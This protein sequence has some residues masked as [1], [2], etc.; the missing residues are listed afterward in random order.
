MSEP[1][2]PQQ[3]YLRWNNH[4]NNLQNVF[5]DLLHDEFFVD[6]TLACDG[7]QLKAH[8]M[9]L[10]A[11]SPYFR[12]I[13]SDTPA[14]H[15]IIYFQDIMYSEMKSLL[16]FMYRGEVSVDQENLSS[17]LKV[18][19]SLKIKGLTEANGQPHAT[20]VAAS[21]PPVK[22]HPLPEPLHNS[23]F[24]PRMRDSFGLHSLQGHLT[25]HSLESMV[26]STL[27]NRLADSSTIHSPLLFSAL[28]DGSSYL[29][30]KRKRGRPRRL[31]GFE[32]I[33]LSMKSN[34]ARYE[35]HCV[36][37]EEMSLVE[38]IEKVLFFIFSI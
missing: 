2:I 6:V 27:A 17:L 26:A 18:A 19:E 29:G 9:V 7:M 5:E 1:E 35:Q 8:K 20:L 13:L 24:N 38:K 14:K 36:K 21:E 32:P 30:P 11:C 12:S 28:K 3:Y 25:D 15:P 4:Q 31:S 22:H 16:D 10:S 33:P 23:L 34:E 37:S